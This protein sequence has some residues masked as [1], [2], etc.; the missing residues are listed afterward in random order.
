[1]SK[2]NKAFKILMATSLIMLIG[3]TIETKA[4]D[5]KTVELQAPNEELTGLKIVQ[6]TDLHLSENYSLTSLQGLVDKVN[7]LKPDLVFFTGDLIDSKST[8]KI[9]TKD[10]VEVL[11]KL[12]SAYGKF[13]VLGNHDTAKNTQQVKT[14]LED[15]KFTLLR[16]SSK[17]LKVNNYKMNIC[18]VDD[19]ILGDKSI[20]K[21][22]KGLEKDAFKLVLCHEGDLIDKLVETKTNADIYG[23]DYMFSG[24]THGGQVTLPN[25]E[26]T[27]LPYLG[28]KYI[29]G[30]FK[31]NERTN[32]YVSVGVGTTRIPIRIG[33]NPEIVLYEFK[34]LEQVAVD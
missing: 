32:L 17:E 14:I 26:P 16:N 18:G 34:D 27:W 6:F 25:I 8:V 1:M 4:M 21:T 20:T 7:E 11:K 31:I 15:S 33:N 23:I 3:I 30:M 2:L 9:N 24:H 28:K 12:E 13:A 22:F 5:I 19:Y 29:K 10:T